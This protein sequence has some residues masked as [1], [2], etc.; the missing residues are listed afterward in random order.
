MYQS[1][2]RGGYHYQDGPPHGARRVLPHSDYHA[3]FSG[4]G[5]RQGQ[6]SPERRQSFEERRSGRRFGGRGHR[7]RGRGGGGSGGLHDD[8]GVGRGR[9]R[10]DSHEQQPPTHPRQS[11]PTT[12]EDSRRPGSK[13]KDGPREGHYEKEG[14][15]GNLPNS[16]NSSATR[17]PNSQADHEMPPPSWPA[18]KNSPEPP[19]QESRPFKIISGGPNTNRG[20]TSTSESKGG[21]SFR[22]FALHPPKNKRPPSG[23]P[24]ASREQPSGGQPR[25]SGVN[26]IPLGKNVEALKKST[27]RETPLPSTLSTDDCREKGKI[28]QVPETP[29]AHT[30]IRSQPPPKESIYTRLSMVGEGTYG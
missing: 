16:R 13:S 1:P 24:G 30:T 8:P 25:G 5:S 17:E 10:F 23:A 22:P 21:S 27:K 28:P 29:K 12:P 18:S 9:N 15:N 20:S 2:S 4:R 6:F 26:N 11:R 7:G 19:L 3:P 14:D